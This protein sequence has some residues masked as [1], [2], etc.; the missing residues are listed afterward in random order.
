MNSNERINDPKT[1]IMNVCVKMFLEKGYKKTT[2]LDIIKEANVSAG[3]FQNIFK[4][5]DGVLRELVDAMFDKQFDMAKVNFSE[6]VDPVYLYALETSIQLTIV[7]LNE[8]L[9]EIYVEAYTQPNISDYI[10]DKTATELYKM[11]KHY[12]PDFQE[13][14]FYE[15]EIGTSSVM[16]G[17]MN[18]PCDKYFTLNHKLKRFLYITLSAFRVPQK[19][20]DEIVNKILSMDIVSIANNVMKELFRFLAVEFKFELTL[21]QI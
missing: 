4:T 19:I 3:T 13:S 6:N 8:N 18:R 9:R 20:Q 12:L 16:R 2:M 17:Y 11:F 10:C 14:D 1:R 21:A 7:E 5:K 15:L